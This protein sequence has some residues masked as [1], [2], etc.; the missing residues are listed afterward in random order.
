MAKKGKRRS[1][2]RQTGVRRYKKLFILGTEGKVTEKKYFDMLR[3]N[4]SVIHIV[5]P[6]GKHKNTPLE[7]LN[8]T[9]RTILDYGLRDND[10]AWIVVDR[11]AWQASD[12][13]ILLK[14]SKGRSAFHLA[15]SNPKFEVWLLYHFEDGKGIKSSRDCSDRLQKILPNFAKSHVETEKLKPNI[16]RAISRAKETDSPPC[17][18]WPTRYGTTVYRLVENIIRTE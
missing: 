4:N 1:F 18:K 7:L 8:K 16:E 17:K 11:D 6:K 3:K 5:Y 10:E 14:W 15:V 13:E 9:K 2:K 12:L